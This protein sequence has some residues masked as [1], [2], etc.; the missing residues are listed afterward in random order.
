MKQI[1]GN[2]AALTSRTNAAEQRI[3]DRAVE[4]DGE[5]SARLDE[6]RPTAMFDDGV[7]QEYQ[8]LVLE[9]AKLAQVTG[10]AKQRIGRLESISASVS[11][12]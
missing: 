10:L 11:G 5:V 2:L 3:H 4:R 9:R 6:L 12:T 1:L 7:A 8:A